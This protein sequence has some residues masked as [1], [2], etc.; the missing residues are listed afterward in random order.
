MGQTRDRLLKL[1]GQP[2]K[3]RLTR[4]YPGD[5]LHN[6]FVLGI[7][8]E[9][10]LFHP[11]HDFYPEGYTALRVADIKRVRSGKHERFWEVMLRGEGLME[12]VG[13]S[14]D[15]PLDD[16]RSLLVALHE[17]DQYVTISCE[18]R[19]PDDDGFFIGR[20]VALDHESVSILHF[21]ALG[22]WDE[23]PF[24]IAYG[25]ITQVQF[26]TPYINTITKYL[27]KPPPGYGLDPAS[28]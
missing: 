18:S 24:V 15:L 21:D 22:N 28:S 10:V 5:P 13:I 11:F 7:G 14:D 16:F 20:V 27:K 8:H 19:E 6:G 3:A 23:E 17:R 2:K 9:L 12:R 25:Y 1:V 4:S 26:D